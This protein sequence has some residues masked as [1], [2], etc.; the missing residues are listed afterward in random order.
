VRQTPT[1]ALDSSDEFL[2]R[3]TP[4]AFRASTLHPQ[5]IPLAGVIGAAADEIQQTYKQYRERRAR[6]DVTREHEAFKAALAAAKS[7]KK[8]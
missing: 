4:E 5:G 2:R 8:Q 3:V 7:D 1:K 6:S